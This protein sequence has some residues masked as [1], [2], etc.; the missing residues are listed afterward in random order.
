VDFEAV[1][2]SEILI[3][4]V[5]RD[6]D[7]VD[8]ALGEFRLEGLVEGFEFLDVGV[9]VRAVGLGVVGVGLS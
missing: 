9:G 8:G 3:G 2:R 4:V 6:D 5:A 1:A 7:G